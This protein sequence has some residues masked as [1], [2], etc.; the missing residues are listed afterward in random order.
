MQAFFRLQGT[1]TGLQYKPIQRKSRPFKAS[2]E[3]LLICTKVHALKK[4]EN[5]GN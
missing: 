2:I 5:R 1:A 3:D 4:Q